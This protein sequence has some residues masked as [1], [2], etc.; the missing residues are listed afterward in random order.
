MFLFRGG[1]TVG[2]GTYWEPNTGKKVVLEDKGFLP[3]GRVWYYKLPES[4]FLIP[5]SLYALI[6]SMAFPYGIGLALFG[7][8]FVLY[9]ILFSLTTAC[10]KFLGRAVSHLFVRYKLNES[11][12]SGRPKKKR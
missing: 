10:E 8:M 6:L 4:Y 2:K 12:F 3:V 7:I 1:E 9:R 11:F 5:L